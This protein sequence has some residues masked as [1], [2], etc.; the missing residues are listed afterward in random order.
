MPGIYLPSHS[1]HSSADFQ[2]PSA[3]AKLYST[4]DGRAWLIRVYD[5]DPSIFWIRRFSYY[6]K[7]IDLFS[8]IHSISSL[9]ISYCLVNNCSLD[10]LSIRSSISH[11]MS[12]EM[13]E[14]FDQISRIS[15]SNYEVLHSSEL[16]HLRSP[17]IMFQYSPTKSSQ[18]DRF[19]RTSIAPMSTISQ[20][21]SLL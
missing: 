9:L 7:C 19:L 21:S 14:F 15:K 3:T 12:L 20:S 2:P 5:S 18:K 10:F 13:P 1:E 17:P 8:F 6:N 4:P 16:K 11:Y